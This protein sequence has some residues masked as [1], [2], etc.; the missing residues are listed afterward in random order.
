MAKKKRTKSKKSIRAEKRRA[1]AAQRAKSK[2]QGRA[3]PAGPFL[4]SIPLPGGGQGLCQC[5]ICDVLRDE[6][7]EVPQVV[8]VTDE[9]LERIREGGRAA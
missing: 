2:S 5:P 4:L 9:I 7:G 6:L 1:K 8:Q 3:R